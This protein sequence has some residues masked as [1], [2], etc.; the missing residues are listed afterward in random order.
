MFSLNSESLFI[1]KTLAIAVVRHLRKHCYSYHLVT[2]EYIHFILKI[3]FYVLYFFPT[4]SVIHLHFFSVFAF[5]LV[6]SCFSE[7]VYE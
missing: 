1:P 2:S 4:S 3:K 5:L 6:I 7:C